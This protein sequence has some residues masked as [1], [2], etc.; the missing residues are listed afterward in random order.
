MFHLGGAVAE[1]DECATA[2]SRRDVAHEVNINA[3]WLPHEPIGDAE[4]AWAKAFFAGLQPR[5]AGAY[6]NF[7]DSDDEP[8]KSDAFGTVAYARLRELQHRFDP[9]PS[10]AVFARPRSVPDGQK[11]NGNQLD[12][13]GHFRFGLE[14]TP[15]V[16]SPELSQALDAQL[17][18]HRA[19][20]R[21]VH[22]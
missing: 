4:T 5:S 11:S 20:E 19:C 6:R 17:H 21:V 7:F 1:V 22:S 10:V 8:R 12:H 3:V 16:M 15:R 2:Y 14:T 18:W 13:C 9:R